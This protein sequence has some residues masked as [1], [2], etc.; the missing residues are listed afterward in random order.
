MVTIRDIAKHAGVS[1]STA[2]RALNNHPKISQKT[3][4]K[5]KAIADEMGYLPNY[6]AK[7]LT[8]G[9]SNA[10]GV[11]FPPGEMSSAA[12]PFYVDILMGINRELRPR[13]GVLSV[14]IANTM[15]ELAANVSALITQGLIRYFVLLYSKKNDPIIKL[16]RAQ[17]VAY[18]VIGDPNADD[19][20]FVN[21]N[22]QLAGQKAGEYML[23]KFNASRTLFVESEPEQGFERKRRLGF[24]QAMAAANIPSEVL[25]I[26]EKG[27][28]KLDDAVAQFL[29]TRQ[30]IDGI[31]TTDDT[32][33]QMIYQLLWR[34]LDRSVPLIC[35]NRNRTNNLLMGPSVR[36]VE[37][38]PQS[39]GAAAVRVLMDPDKKSEIIPFTI[40][41]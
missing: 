30:T 39:M 14:A 13:N 24:Q 38:Y 29:M 10:I 21:N 15:A 8:N 18:V 37:L 16:L 11:V 17:K 19:E 23:K 25:K 7:N 32:L 12:N 41:R 34:H 6:N 35:F 31:V 22:N 3:R 26:S 1:V 27:Q 2:S 36:F 28:M 33:G 4:D 9:V 5:I 20:K 40:E